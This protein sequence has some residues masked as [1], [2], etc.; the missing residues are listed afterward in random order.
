[1]E[2]VK[3]YNMLDFAM[4]KV[5]LLSTGILLG[6][7]FYFVFMHI[8]SIIWIIFAISFLYIFCISFFKKRKK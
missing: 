2:N 3:N 4:F 6:T 1:M 8:I 5:V 7:Y